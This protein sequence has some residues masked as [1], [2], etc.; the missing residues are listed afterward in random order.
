MQLNWI[1]AQ[2]QSPI[3]VLIAAAFKTACANV[4]GFG[5][6]SAETYTLNVMATLAPD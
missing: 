4:D 1:E 6:A 2:W 3:G 5:H